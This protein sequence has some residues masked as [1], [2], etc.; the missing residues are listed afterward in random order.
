MKTTKREPDV[1]EVW[2]RLIE[3]VDLQR[4][5]SVAIA[6]SLGI[7]RQHMQAVLALGV[8][9]AVTMSVLAER[10]GCQNANL[11]AVVVDLEAQRYVARSVGKH[12]KRARAVALTAKGQKLRAEISERMRSVPSPL[13]RL[14]RVHLARLDDELH[15][16]LGTD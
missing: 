11:T 1:I 9:E 4:D 7:S 12:D 6:H 5:A 8:G 3:L 15:T 2:N 16:A 13:S 14:S 10:C